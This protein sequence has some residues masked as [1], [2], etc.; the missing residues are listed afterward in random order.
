M[1]EKKKSSWCSVFF[2]FC[3]VPLWRTV[4]LLRGLL[5]WFESHVWQNHTL[6]RVIAV[7][8]MLGGTIWRDYILSVHM[9][10]KYR[11]SS[12]PVYTG[13]VK[14]SVLSRWFEEWGLQMLIVCWDLDG[15]DHYT[16][17]QFSGLGW[18]PASSQLCLEHRCRLYG[19]SIL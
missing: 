5:C 13:V 7:G 10:W 11:A 2:L 18:S 3:F 1:V 9:V 4:A 8:Q 16:P 14:I 17:G 12:G 15:F 19:G 6:P